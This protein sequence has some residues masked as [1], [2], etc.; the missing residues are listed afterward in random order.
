MAGYFFSIYKS[1]S[2]IILVKWMKLS[3]FSLSGTSLWMTCSWSTIAC[4]NCQYIWIIFY[5]KTICHIP[6]CLISP[7]VHF[8]PLIAFLC[9]TPQPHCHAFVFSL[10]LSLSNSYF[11]SICLGLHLQSVFFC[12]PPLSFNL[13]PIFTYCHFSQPSQAQCFAGLLYPLTEWILA[14]LAL[15][16]TD[17]IAH[18]RNIVLCR[19]NDE[20]KVV[21]ADQ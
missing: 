21:I 9:L 20:E 18:G 7:L 5:L 17:T 2:T 10:F 3:L 4:H 14:Q 15:H 16:H 12:S 13:L 11:S 6:C 1:L 8:L 19:I